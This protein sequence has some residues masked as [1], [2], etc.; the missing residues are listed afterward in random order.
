MTNFLLDNL[1]SLAF[2]MERSG[3]MPSF[4]GSNVVFFPK[5]ILYTFFDGV[6]SLW[7]GF[8]GFYGV[9]VLYRNIKE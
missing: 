9:G 6:W 7:Y 3:T 5:V 8:S 4:G 2:S 1:Q